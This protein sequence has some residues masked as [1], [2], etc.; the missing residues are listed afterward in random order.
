M[1]VAGAPANANVGMMMKMMIDTKCWLIRSHG[2]VEGVNQNC[3][4]C[5]SERIPNGIPVYQ[6]KKLIKFA[7]SY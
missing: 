4:G 2:I 1:E 6:M 7:L 3:N 5:K